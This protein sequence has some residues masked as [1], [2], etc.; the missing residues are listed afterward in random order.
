MLGVYC[1][2]MSN[3]VRESRQNVVEKSSGSVVSVL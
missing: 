2:E 3:E 1:V